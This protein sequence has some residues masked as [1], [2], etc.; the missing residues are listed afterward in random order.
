LGGRSLTA[1]FQGVRVI[2]ATLLIDE[3]TWRPQTPWDYAAGR[4]AEELLLLAKVLRVLDSAHLRELV[5][6]YFLED[7]TFMTKLTVSA[8]GLRRIE[9]MN[10]SSVE[11]DNH[12]RHVFDNLVADRRLMVYRLA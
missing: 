10:G 8:E 6:Y 9:K 7:G 3:A 1:V 12:G 4:H 5:V 2:V 11:P